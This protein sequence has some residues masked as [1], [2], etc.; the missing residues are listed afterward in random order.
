MNS[1]VANASDFIARVFEPVQ[2]T[3]R[4]DRVFFTSLSIAFFVIALAGFAPTYYLKSVFDTP[5]PPLSPLLHVHGVVFTSWLVL[6]IAQTSLIANGQRRLH[7]QLGIAG[8][9]LALAM[10]V[11]GLMTAI[12]AAR[13]PV[14]GPLGLPRLVFLTV[15]FFSIL[16]FAIL[17]A[18]AIRYRRQADVHKRLIMLAT[19]DILGA[20]LARLPGVMDIGPLG[21]IGLPIVLILVIAVYDYL[22]RG[23]IHPVTLFVGTLVALCGAV[24]IPIGMTESWLAFARWLTA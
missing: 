21:V 12:E 19:I 17:V 22:S 13:L 24:R 20:P 10:L 14:P 18:F 1:P 15:P 5:T 11:I 2:A 16:T 23:R 6:L 3:P 8:S 7:M 4:S 9:V